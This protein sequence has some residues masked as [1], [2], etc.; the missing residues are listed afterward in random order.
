MAAEKWARVQYRVGRAVAWVG[1]HSGAAQIFREALAD[2]P[3][4]IEALYSLCD[5]LMQGERWVEAAGA[6]RDLTQQV[7]ASVELQGNLVL[8]LAR[9]GDQDAAIDALDRMIRLR[10]FQPE[11]HLLKGAL[12][13]KRRQHGEAIR[14]FRWAVSLGHSAT[15][16][17]FQLGEAILG[18]EH[19]QALL[20]RYESALAVPHEGSSF[21]PSASALNAPPLPV[22]DSVAPDGEPFPLARPSGPQTPSPPRRL[23]LR[24]VEWGEL[25]AGRW[26]VLLDRH[27]KRGDPHLAI[28]RYRR[29]WALRSERLGTSPNGVGPHRIGS[30]ADPDASAGQGER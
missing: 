3:S 26:Q 23:S 16:T 28:R 20:Q 8:C 15:V 30:L 5:A 13:R 22:L 14:A 11:L 4:L 9:A 18:L 21:E 25:L 10:P 7:P 2:D 24:L 19:W 29:A 12:Y 27:F 1:W 6:L 17:R